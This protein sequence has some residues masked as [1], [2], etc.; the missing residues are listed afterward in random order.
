MHLMILAKLGTRRCGLDRS[1]SIPRGPT[2]DGRLVTSHCEASSLIFDSAECT[3]FFAFS[4]VPTLSVLVAGLTVEECGL[5][6]VSVTLDG[7]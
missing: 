6:Q 3:F 5:S 1:S 4:R 7:Q 2:P